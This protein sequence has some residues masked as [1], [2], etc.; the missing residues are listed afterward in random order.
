MKTRGALTLVFD[1]G[2]TAVYEQVIPL[3]RQYGVRAVFAVPLNTKEIE[4]QA[5]TS[6]QEWLSIAARDGH[7]IVAHGITHR[8]FTALS[9]RELAQELSEPAETL[10][11]STLVYPGGAHD[12]RVVNAAKKHFKAARTVV[13]GLNNIRPED[14][15]RLKTINFSKRNFSVPRANIHAL[16]VLFQNKWLI[17]TYHMVSCQPS[18]LKHSVLLDDL[19]GHLDFITSLPTKITTIEEHL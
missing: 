11:T 5:I 13:Y 1:D 14:Q 15:M 3:L 4:G 12:D 6:P 17:E 2:Y 18:T 7:E 8:S 19:E 10:R 9:D 16:R